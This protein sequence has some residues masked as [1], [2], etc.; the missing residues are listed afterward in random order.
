MTKEQVKEIAWSKVVTE[1]EEISGIPRKQV[2]DVANQIVLGIE[3][4]V[5]KNQPKRDDD[6]LTIETP[7]ICYK[8][9]REPSQNIMRPDGAQFTRP[10]CISGNSSVPR[11][12]IIK[13]NVGLA[14]KATAATEA[15]PEKK[16]K[17][18]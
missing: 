18:A 14:D 8:F 3:S 1:V 11:N 17:L 5:E 16:K 2:D 4:I 12:F 15:E 13:A 6:E 7:F 9:K 10:A